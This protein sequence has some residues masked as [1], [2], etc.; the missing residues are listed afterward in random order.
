MAGN[1]N[2]HRLHDLQLEEA[3]MPFEEAL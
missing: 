3:R 2:Q 1:Y